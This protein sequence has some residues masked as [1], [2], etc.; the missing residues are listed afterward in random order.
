[1]KLPYRAAG[2]VLALPIFH[3]GEDMACK[4]VGYCGKAV[5]IVL[6]VLV[7]PVLVHVAEHVAVKKIESAPAQPISGPEERSEN[8]GPRGPASEP[9][10]A[11]TLTPQSSAQRAKAAAPPEPEVIQVIVQGAGWTPAEAVQDG[12]RNAV[13]HVAADL[14]GTGNDG[15][16]TVTLCDEVLRN[17]TGIILGWNEV[18]AQKEWR[19][20]GSFHHKGLVVAVNRQALWVRW[21]A[22]VNAAR[23][24]YRDPRSPALAA[25]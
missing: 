16:A 13:K 12:L 23:V 9:S 24:R 20:R 4:L 10:R 5:A 2:V 19:L 18:G 21:Q 15:Q 22:L 17:S 3:G 8:A 6:T 25:R 1:L 7:A 11:L 14:G